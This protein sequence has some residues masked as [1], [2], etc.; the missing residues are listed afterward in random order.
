VYVARALI[1]GGDLSLVITVRSGAAWQRM[2]P[3]Q[4]SPGRARASSWREE[5]EVRGQKLES[6]GLF[7]ATSFA[8]RVGDTPSLSL[9]RQCVIKHALSMCVY[10]CVRATG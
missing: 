2:S 9:P 4:G 10:V 5:E 1:K 7:A 3:C 6:K 8:R